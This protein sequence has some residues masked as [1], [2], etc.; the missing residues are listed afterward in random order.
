MWAR[1]VSVA[2]LAFP[3]FCCVLSG[4]V[5]AANFED[6][7]A[8]QV[9]MAENSSA[10][11]NPDQSS[12]RTSLGNLTRQF[13]N[14]VL[15]NNRQPDLRTINGGRLCV[16]AWGKQPSHYAASGRISPSQCADVAMRVPDALGFRW[17]REGY[18]A[19]AYNR[20]TKLDSIQRPVNL[21]E[22]FDEDNKDF[23]C[24]IFVGRDLDS[25]EPLELATNIT[26]PSFFP[27][28]GAVVEG[29]GSS[30]CFQR[31]TLQRFFC[32]SVTE[33]WFCYMP[34]AGWPKCMENNS[35]KN[36]QG[37]VFLVAGVIF[38][39]VLGYIMRDLPE[40]ETPL[41][42]FTRLLLC[43]ELGVVAVA[44]LLKAGADAG[45]GF[46]LV[47]VV[48][49]LFAQYTLLVPYRILEHFT[50]NSPFNTFYLLFLAFS[51][52]YVGETMSYYSAFP[53]LIDKWPIAMGLV[54]FLLDSAAHVIKRTTFG[55]PIAYEPLPSARSNYEP[56]TSRPI[57]TKM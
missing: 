55:Q 15:T 39:A 53:L 50:E 26:L 56:M 51:P 11:V 6:G 13:G 18:S 8:K 22:I 34:E 32:P 4:L 49:V 47:A 42:W 5:R 30:V 24:S 23:E 37:V 10:D 25:D 36:Q 45:P 16:G 3:L 57:S 44:Q 43:M 14:F 28:G 9:D 29:P 46:E 19:D 21:D 31:W 12:K 40:F 54:A 1:R 27:R 7:A 35:K 52:C 17:G 33:L 38:M 41:L 2:R 20:Y 48:L